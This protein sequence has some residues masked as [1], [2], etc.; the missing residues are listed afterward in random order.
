[1]MTAAAAN[2]FSLEDERWDGH[3]VFTYYLLEGLRGGGDGDGDGI[4]TFTELY[5]FVYSSVR[6]ATE[7]RQNPQRAGLGDI[8]LAL[9]AAPP[10]PESAGASAR[11]PR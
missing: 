9:V 6:N 10:E 1:M 3:G 4:V 5:D 2:E 8:P 11:V 7:G